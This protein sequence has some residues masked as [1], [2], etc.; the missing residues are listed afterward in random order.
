MKAHV[1]LLGLALVSAGLPACSADKE[2]AAAPAAST[3]S[4]SSVTAQSSSAAPSSSSTA[5]QAAAGTTTAPSSSTATSTSSSAATS[6]PMVGGMTE[7]TKE[8]LAGPALAAVQAMGPDNLYTVD[9]LECADGWAVTG[10]VLSSKANPSMG[11]PTSI[12]FQQEGQFWVVQDK[13]KV[14][15]TD[16]VTTTP[17]PDAAIPAALFLSGCAAG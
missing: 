15:G 5:T 13:A 4:S 17:P 7:C 1:T 11:A 16:P 9:S 2:P 8:A 6:T 14:C 3:A 10:G 12:V